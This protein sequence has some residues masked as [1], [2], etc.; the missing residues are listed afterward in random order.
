MAFPPETKKE[1]WLALRTDGALG[2]GS[3]TDPYDASSPTLF[4]DRMDSFQ[5]FTTIH[6]GPGIFQTRGYNGFTGWQA[7]SGQRIIG[8]GMNVTTLKLVEASL[9]NILTVAIGVH[10]NN[11]LSGFEASDFTVDCNLSAQPIASVACGAISLTGTRIRIRR[12]RAINWG[13]QVF[14]DP[15]L[16]PVPYIEGFVIAAGGPYPFLPEV[17]DCLV[18]DC[19]IE[20][21]SPNNAWVSTCINLGAGEDANGVMAYHQRGVIRNCLVNCEYSDNAVPISVITF[22]GTT[23][24]VSTKFPHG[25]APGQWL[26]VTGALEN[27]TPSAN[28]NGSFQVTAV[29]SATQFQYT[30]TGTPST[31][32]TG[33]MFLGK[34]ASF[35]VPIQNISLT[36]SGSVWIATLTTL[37]P[38]NRVMGNNG[39]VNGVTTIDP[40]TGLPSVNNA[41]NG[42]FA[43]T[44][45]VS[46]TMLRYI[47]NSDPG[48]ADFTGAVLGVA[49]NGL[50]A[51]GGIGAIVEGNRV[52]NCPSAFF[53]D[54]YSTNDVLIRNN[55]FYNVSFGVNQSLGGFSTGPQGL[56]HGSSLTSS[57]TVATFTTPTPHGFSVGQ[58]VQ[59]ASALVGGN[60]TNPYNGTFPVLSVSSPTAF[61]YEMGSPTSPNPDTP[62]DVPAPPGIPS[63]TYAALWQV[64]RLTV[65]KNVVEMR[66]DPVLDAVPDPRAATAGISLYAGGATALGYPYVFQQGTIRRN[67]VRHVDN[68]QSNAPAYYHFGIYVNSCLRAIVEDNVINV[69]TPLQQVTV[70]AGKYFNN[71]TPSGSLTQGNNYSPS[72]FVNEL[73]TD[74]D[75]GLLLS[76]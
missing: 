62:A 55:C 45:I 38:H 27:G 3:A 70:G 59:V 18:E 12:I 48:T 29:L 8:A 64:W 15:A 13:T 75:L 14:P 57:G 71:Q 1:V 24:T 21:P 76:T 56:R 53:H 16:S 20:K 23:A 4:D 26:V 43:I 51:D 41:F 63:F 68:A 44:E 9:A 54:T 66:L 31:A 72:Q 32:P 65:E 10:A 37:T 28:Y 52:Y 2:S 5:T 58:A 73:A 35:A 6:L 19:V 61:T 36:S 30:M 67:V 33:D 25:R 22:S 74:A 39:V 40:I 42:S 47:M 46:P 50:G 11:F 60:P 17:A 34:A 69:S 7:K 49:F